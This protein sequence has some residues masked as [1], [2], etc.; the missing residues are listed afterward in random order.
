MSLYYG[1]DQDQ[2][3][4]TDA[5]RVLFLNPPFLPKFS[6]SQRSP[7]VI[8]SG[9]LYYPLWLA[10]AAGLCEQHGYEIRLLDAP[11]ARSRLE[12]VVAVSRSFAPQLIILDTSTPSIQSDIKVAEAI[13]A[14]C[15]ATSIIAVGPHAS[16]LPAETLAAGTSLDAI[17]RGEYDLTV[18]EAAQ[19]VEG[20]AGLEHV[21]GLTV[22]LTDGSI[23]HN[24]D[25]A[26]I[27]NLDDL[28]FVSKVYQ[29]HLNVADYFYSITQYPEVALVTGR[30]C[31]YGCTYCVWPQTLTGRR[32]RV[33]SV[34][35]VVDEFE[36]IA[37]EMPEVREVF[38]EDDTL[39]AN[40]KRAV[41]LAEELIR[42]DIHLAFTANSRADVDYETLR[43]LHAA[44]L[45]LL[46]VG[47]ESG[48]QSILDRMQKGIRIEQF[49][50]FRAAA[51]KAGVLVHGCFMAGYPGETRESLAA[52]LRLALEL[53]PDTAQFFPLMVYPG[54][55]A[56]D[57]VRRNGMLITEDY[58]QWLTDDGLHRS[59]VTLPTISSEE[60]IAWCDHAR[61]VFY[62]RPRYLL[63]KTGQIAR[64]PGEARRILKSAGVFL[65]YLFRPTL[66]G[67]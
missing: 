7:A 9:V 53:D 17:A 18:L 16:A 31:P 59:T 6:R 14:S 56:Y 20:G 22:R 42:R 3:Y 67:S 50:E 28:P 24:P 45:R 57:Y 51:R 12:D 46:C 26:L 48:E 8:R 34:K 27:E 43:C 35:H 25:R 21:L 58:R 39:T 23:L 64:H 11:A 36:F 29:K 41:A 15:P 40:P 61:R 38:I 13:K 30:G 33:R 2:A 47:F 63:A 44:G 10:Q 5:M 66:N 1:L 62:T 19:A 49:H 32:Y 55:V 65:H 37:T 4:L 52:T 54:T 60:L